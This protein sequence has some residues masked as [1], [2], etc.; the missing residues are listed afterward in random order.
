MLLAYPASIAAQLQ[1]TN[2][3]DIEKMVK[4]T[5]GQST[6]LVSSDFIDQILNLTLGGAFGSLGYGIYR[7][8]S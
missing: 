2:R 7:E 1:R 6:T 4:D 8:V 5:N 3:T